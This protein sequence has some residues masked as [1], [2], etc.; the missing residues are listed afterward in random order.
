MPEYPTWLYHATEAPV[1][2]QTPEEHAALGRG[3]HD[4]PVSGETPEEP[5]PVRPSR[6][7]RKRDA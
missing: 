2:V 4:A 3:W 7:P 5:E 6:R 1:L